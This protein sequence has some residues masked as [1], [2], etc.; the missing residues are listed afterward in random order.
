MKKVG[1]LIALVLVLVA[2]PGCSTLY[3][4]SYDQSVY[5]G[6]KHNLSQWCDDDCETEGIW[7][8]MFD[9]I[10]SVIGDTAALPLT[11]PLALCRCDEDYDG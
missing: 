4:L 1:G 8:S 2:A 11:M 3:D 10:P 6:T 9:F 7:Y 5:G